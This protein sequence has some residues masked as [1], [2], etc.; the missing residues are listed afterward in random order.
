[1]KSKVIIVGAGIGGLSTAIRLLKE[2][3]EV[4]IIEKNKFIGGK[5]NKR[6][7]GI[8]EYDLTASIIMM[9]KEY[10]EVFRE[11]NRDLNDYVQL[12]RI[13]PLYR[14]FYSDKSYYDF[15][16]DL[17]KLISMLEENFPKDTLGYLEVLVESFN[18]YKI[19]EECFLNQSFNKAKEFFNIETMYKALNIRT[20]TSIYD[21]L[22]QYIENYKL[23]EYLSFQ[24]MYVGVSP[25]EGP[26]IYTII[27]ATTEMYGLWYIEGGIYTYVEALRKLVEELG[28]II[29]TENVL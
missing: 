13:D 19:A 29:V 14:V 17:V 4:K 22:S 18:K 7:Q 9:P 1:M 6:I 10:F 11:A 20:F 12:K 8:M 15:S 26:N 2:G 3:Y 27:P 23:K 5:V 21:Y 25:Y 16:S 24:A 28:G